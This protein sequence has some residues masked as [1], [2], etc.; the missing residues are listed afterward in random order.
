M[1]G[2]QYHRTFLG[3]WP[4]RDVTTS[5]SETQANEN[6]NYVLSML[7]SCSRVIIFNAAENRHQVEDVKHTELEESESWKSG[8]SPN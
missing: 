2:I 5:I 6:I 4:E 3:K 7:P 8:Y 1:I